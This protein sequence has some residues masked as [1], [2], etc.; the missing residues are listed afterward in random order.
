MNDLKPLIEKVIKFRND[1]DWKQFHNPKDVAISLVLEATEY[2]ELFQWKNEKEIQKYI[3]ENKESLS[4]ELAD[5][6]YYVLLAC[7][8]LN[9][10]PENALLNKM[11]KN[12]DKY[13]VNKSKGKHTKYNKL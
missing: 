9:I 5:I 1:R 13:P 10:N 4:D 6:L 8:D 3:N 12:G 7:Y 2:L 11:K